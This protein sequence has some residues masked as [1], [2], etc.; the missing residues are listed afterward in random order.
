MEY[1]KSEG[2]FYLNLIDVNLSTSKHYNNIMKEAVV[3]V[4][5][6]IK[7]TLCVSSLL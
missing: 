6:E 1:S 4:Y 3:S 5:N 2:T 7:S